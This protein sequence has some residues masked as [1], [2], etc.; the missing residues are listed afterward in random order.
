MKI[1]TDPQSSDAWFATRLGKLTASNAQTIQAN[2]AG[3]DTYVYQKVAE[4]LSGK[5]EEIYTNADMERG[6]ELEDTARSSYEM[7]TGAKVQQVGFCELDQYTGASPDGFVGEDGLVEIKCPRGANYVRVLHT[8]KI[9]PKYDWQIQMQLHVTGRK[10]CDYVVFHENFNDLIIIRV[11]RDEDKIKK[12]VAGLEAGVAKI[13][14][15]LKE[16]K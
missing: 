16:L 6:N 7:E 14:Q 9:D 15:I 4:I 10:W 13:K 1:Y 12:I 3:L 11:N 5:M 8:K 2:G